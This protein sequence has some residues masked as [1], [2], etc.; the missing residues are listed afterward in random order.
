VQRLY[1]NGRQDEAGNL[2]HR[3]LP[4]ILW[5][6][7][8]IDFSVKSAKEELQRRGIF[9]TAHQRQPAVAL[10][11]TSVTQLSRWI[12]ARLAAEIG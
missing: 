3:E 8:S 9:R 10:D 4:F 7:Q 1:E 11:Q 12:D 2:F 5:A 6:M